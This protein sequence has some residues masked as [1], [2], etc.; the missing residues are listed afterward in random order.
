M[1]TSLMPLEPHDNLDWTISVRLPVVQVQHLRAPVAPE[2]CHVVRELQKVA[3]RLG[4]SQFSEEEMGHVHAMMRNVR[5]AISS[6]RSDSRTRGL[7]RRCKELHV[8]RSLWQSKRERGRERARCGSLSL[9][10]NVVLFFV[11][12]LLAVLPT[13]LC[14]PFSS[15]F[16]V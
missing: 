14:F 15:Q 3:S 9:P 4:H 5:R 10:G 13:H 6:E 7:A 2:L 11:L 8:D 1:T 16:A 12:F